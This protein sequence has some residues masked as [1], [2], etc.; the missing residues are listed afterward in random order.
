MVTSLSSTITSLVKKSAPIVA[1]Y[2]LLNLLLTYWFIKEVFPTLKR[3]KKK[4]ITDSHNLV[5][6]SKQALHCI[7][8]IISLA[9]RTINKYNS[10]VIKQTVMTEQ[11]AYQH[12]CFKYQREQEESIKFLSSGTET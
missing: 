9:I 5:L 8:I 4:N 7:N 2:W 11:I 6:Q 10:E 3:K 1:L 12:Y